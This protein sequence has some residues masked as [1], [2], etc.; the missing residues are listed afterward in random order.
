LISFI[1]LINYF[2]ILADVKLTYLDKRYEF[3]VSLH[4]LGVLLLYNGANMFTFKEIIE[5]TGLNDQEL[6]R[7][8]KV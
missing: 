3:S 6:K 8:I 2:I 4:Q 7:V 5:H 1:I